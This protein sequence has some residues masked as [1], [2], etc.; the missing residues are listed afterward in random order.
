[1]IA[2]LLFAALA[3]GGTIR[4][5][6]TASGILLI[7][8]DFEAMDSS[9]VWRAMSA[10]GIH[11][12][13]IKLDTESPHSGKNCLMFQ[14]APGKASDSIFTGIPL[15]ANHGSLVRVR[16]FARTAGMESKD[17]EFNL[18][19][20]DGPKVIGWCGG[21]QTLAAIDAGPQWKAYSV[22]APL[23]PNAR[24]LTLMLKLNEPTAN[25]TVWI[26]DL[27]FEFEDA[28]AR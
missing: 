18:L 20:R 3:I 2:K 10:K 13:V 7:N 1:M 16:F 15:P 9:S 23:S 5:A 27:S 24:T 8:F 22:T 11:P 25:K 4:A 21:K 12:P 28:A 6:D 17:A 14:A 26:D 19:E